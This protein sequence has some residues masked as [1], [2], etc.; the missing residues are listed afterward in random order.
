MGLR[1]ETRALEIEGAVRLRLDAV[2]PASGP[3][4]DDCVAHLDRGAALNAC[5]TALRELMSHAYASSFGSDWLMQVAG[6][7]K[8][9]AWEERAV[10]EVRSR[11]GRGAVGVAN[12]GLAYANFYDLVDFADRHWEPLAPAL[13]AKKEVLAL[14]RRLERLRNAVGHSRPLVAFEEDLVSGIAG[15]IRNQV[16]IYMSAQDPA[17]DIYPRIESVMDSFGRRIE[18]SAV[19]GELAGSVNELRHRLASG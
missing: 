6:P 15:Q 10:E 13:G 5:E 14:L 18:S 7:K 1:D 16:T 2:V 11:G 3:C 4:D 17:G 8:V 9:A 12:A 19:T